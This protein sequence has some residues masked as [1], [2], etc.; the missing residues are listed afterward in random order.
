MAGGET[1]E[2]AVAAAQWDREHPRSR[3]H[4]RAGSISHSTAPHRSL[5][6][7]ASPLTCPAPG[8]WPR[9]EG[10]LLLVNFNSALKP[11]LNASSSEKPLLL[12]ASILNTLHGTYP[13]EV[14][15]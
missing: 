12:A 14:L 8:Q 1:V 10:P 7:T 13:G 11:G 2:D 6:L 15:C 3:T 9:A 4:G 5:P